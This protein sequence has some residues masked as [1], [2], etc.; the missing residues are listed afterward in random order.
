MSRPNRRPPIQPAVSP[1]E[2][3]VML[4]DQQAAMLIEYQ[5]AIDKAARAEADYRATRAAAVVEIR[6]RE[7]CPLALAQFKADAS[8]VVRNAHLARNLAEGMVPPIREHLH[9]LAEMLAN[10]RTAVVEQ[11]RADE[12]AAG[13][14][15]SAS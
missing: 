14:Y 11:R 6:T 15:G 12:W 13:G 2:H 8:E 3:L 1:M 5:D 10:G 9:H 7:G 4:G